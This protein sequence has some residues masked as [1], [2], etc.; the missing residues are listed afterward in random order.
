[1]PAAIDFV[2]Q[3]RLN[4]WMGPKQGKV[5]L[6]LQGGMYNSVIRALQYLGLSDAYGNTQVPLYVMNV[7]YPMIDSEVVEFCG[8]K[9]AVLMVE[10]GQ[11][12][13][14]E[15]AVNTVLRRE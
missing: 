4:E 6:I 5:G 11:P 9:N 1:M 7:T 13:Y 15:Q 8:D 10:E 12:E 2:R 3:N 14:L